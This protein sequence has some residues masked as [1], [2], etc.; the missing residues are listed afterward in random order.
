M[1]QLTV[2]EWEVRLGTQVRAVRIAAGL[3]QGD[4]AR[5]A[6][7]SETSVRSLERGGGSTLATLIA[8]AAVL[9]RT[10]WLNEFD[11][12]GDGPSPIELLRESRRQ[13]ARP[14]RVRRP[15]P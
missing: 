9:D 14:Q 10:D 6:S 1:P 8:V 5:S 2:S 15:R 13:P 7:L 11:P 3:T 12:R 4:L